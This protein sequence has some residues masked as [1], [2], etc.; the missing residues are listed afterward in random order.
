M[1]GVSESSGRR[2]RSLC[3]NM[4][5]SSDRHL[6]PRF[7]FVGAVGFLVDAVVLQ[8]LFLLGYGPFLSRAFSVVVAITA[9]WYLNR[10]VVFQTSTAKGPE[11]L[12]HLAAQSVG[13]LVNLIVYGG[14]LLALPVL[15]DM[16]IIALIG[17]SLAAMLFNFFAAKFWT[18]RHGP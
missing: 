15:Q 11:Y 12:R 9:T 17:G 8:T 6:F 2:A 18:F 4:S 10:T 13:M 14:L 1:R 3:I 16:P 5:D 7:V